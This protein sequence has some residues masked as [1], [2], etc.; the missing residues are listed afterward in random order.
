LFATLQ[1]RRRR[2]CF[3]RFRPRIG[4]RIA[5]F[6]TIHLTRSSLHRKAQRGEGC[7]R[8]A[9]VMDEADAFQTETGHQNAEEV[10]YVLQSSAISRFPDTRWIGLLIWY[11]R[12]ESGFLRTYADM[13]E[14]EGCASVDRA[15]TWEVHPHYHPRHPCYRPFA[16]VRVHDT[17]EVPKPYEGPFK[18]N[19]VLAAM[20]YLCKPP[21][22]EGAFFEYPNLLERCSKVEVQPA[23][24]AN[25]SVTTHE[26]EVGVG[27]E[28]TTETRRFPSLYI[29][30]R[31]KPAEAHFSPD[32]P[33]VD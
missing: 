21:P 11:P 33:G 12:S 8:L 24:W 5:V 15:A 17:D 13:A 28:Q 9:W 2:P 3:G 18:N 26:V 30:R 27:E 1:E 32:H 4:K 7:N 14:K 6:A 25:I 31:I 10:H 20:T 19:P 16:T 22:V 29:A 23:L